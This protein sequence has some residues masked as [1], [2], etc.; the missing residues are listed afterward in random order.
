MRPMPAKPRVGVVIWFV[1][2]CLQTLQFIRFYCVSTVLYIKIP[3]YLAGIERMPF[4]ERVLPILFLKP[5]YSSPRF[6]HFAHGT[7]PM[8]AERAPFYLLSL[9][10]FVIAGVFVQKLYGAITQSGKLYFVVYPVFLIVTLWSYVIH[11]D[12][13]FSYPYDMPG[14][15][16]FAA[17]LY[18][19]YTRK[20]LPLFLVMLVGTLNRETTLFLIGLYIFDAATV[21]GCTADTSLR[22]RFALS[23]VSWLRVAIL[24]AIWLAVKLPLNYIFAH[25]DQ[26][27]NFIRF[28]YNLNEMGP[29]MWPSM[30]N[31]CGYLL[32]IV[33]ILRRYIVPARFANY[34]YIMP[35]WFAVMFTSGVIV[36]TRI[37]G[38][39]STY[40]AVALVLI[41]ER[42]MTQS[43]PQVGQAEVQRTERIAV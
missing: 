19:V 12:A 41:V 25:N 22:R 39:L 17:G 1:F 23:Q 13:N 26:S 28:H 6:M 36:E 16:F 42:Y 33:W 43:S 27:E 29:R 37:Y 4:Q 18:F 2:C 11:V 8:T 21:P 38:E 34:L 35:V 31:I 3:K 10:T 15:A 24:C 20:F 5:L 9:V 7:G 30:L 14:L 40:V 32:P